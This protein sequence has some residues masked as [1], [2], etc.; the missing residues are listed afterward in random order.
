MVE[1]EV[2]YYFFINCIF[3]GYVMISVSFYYILSG[4]KNLKRL[5][6]STYVVILFRIKEREMGYMDRCGVCWGFS[7]VW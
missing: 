7:F 3:K 4:G 6:R 2:E 5:I 1:L